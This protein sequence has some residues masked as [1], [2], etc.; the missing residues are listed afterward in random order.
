[1]RALDLHAVMLGHGA[2]GRGMVDM[3][4]G[5]QHLG[6]PDAL[7]VDLL[8]QHVEVAARIDGG[9]FHRLVIPDDGAILLERRDGGDQDLEHGTDV[10]ASNRVE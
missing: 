2:G 1:M 10:M 5:Q 7:L 3:A 6:D 9:A 8:L 4:M